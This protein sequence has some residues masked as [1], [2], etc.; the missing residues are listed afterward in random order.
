MRKWIKSKEKKIHLWL[1]KK[2][3]KR[4]PDILS[5]FIDNRATNLSIW[6][7]M[8][9]LDHEGIFHCQRCPSRFGLMRLTGGGYACKYHAQIITKE[10]EALGASENYNGQKEKAISR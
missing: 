10:V 1:I 4:N 3:A 6:L 7:S 5:D 8:R 2:I 9:I